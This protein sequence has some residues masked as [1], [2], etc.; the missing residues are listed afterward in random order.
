MTLS[1]FFVMMWKDERL[2]WQHDDFASL[3]VSIFELTLYKI[4]F[5]F[6][7]HLY[8]SEKKQSNCRPKILQKSCVFYCRYPI[9]IFGFLT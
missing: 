1:G 8:Q 5:Y 3:H 6:H 9:M 2:A 7:I 4:H